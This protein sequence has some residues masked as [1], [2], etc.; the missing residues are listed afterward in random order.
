MSSA[1]SIQNEEI[2]FSGNFNQIPNWKSGVQMAALNVQTSGP[3]LRLN[4]AMF[5]QNRNS[6]YVLKPCLKKVNNINVIFPNSSG[7]VKF[8]KSFSD[9]FSR[10]IREF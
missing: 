2:F 9:Q 7:G 5:Q 10:Q 4:N 6:G 3:Y 8:S 1:E